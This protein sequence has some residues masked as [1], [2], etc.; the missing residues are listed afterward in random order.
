MKRLL[1]YILWIFAPV[2]SY[3]IRSKKTGGWWKPY[4]SSVKD[5]RKSIISIIKEQ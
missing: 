2:I 3:C 5:I 1:L 4:K